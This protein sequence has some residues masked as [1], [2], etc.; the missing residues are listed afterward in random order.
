MVRSSK[1]IAFSCYAGTLFAFV[2]SHSRFDVKRHFS[3]NSPDSEQLQSLWSANIQ[4]MLAGTIHSPDQAY[5]VGQEL[6]LPLHAA[7]YLQNDAWERDISQHFS[8]FASNPSVLPSVVLDRLEYLYLAA[9]FL[10]L[11]KQSGRTDLVPSP[12]PDIVYSEFSKYWRSTPAWQW[13]RDPFS[14][15]IRERILWKLKNKKVQKSYYRALVDDDLFLLA[16]AADLKAFSDGSDQAPQWAPALD[17]AL[18]IALKVFSQEGVNLSDGGWLFQPGVWTDHPEYQ[19]AGNIVVQSGI[20]PAP[21][22]GIA[23][24]SSHSM[25]FAAWLSSF[26]LAYPPQSDNRLFYDGLRNKL[27]NQF[28]AKMLVPPSS[29]LSCYLLKNFT[30]GSNGV[31]R[32]EYSSLG[33]GSGYGPYQLSGSMLLGWWALLGTDRIRSLYSELDKAFPWTRQCISFYLGPAPGALH[34]ESSYDPNS[35]T[36]RLW[37]TIVALASAQSK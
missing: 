10:V 4:S 35:P 19:Y 24:D 26:A 1:L 29:D 30:D 14:G 23:T 15:G 5:T 34:P 8:R 3:S 25:R 17:D 21:V 31:Y 9:E 7:F 6:L 28:F 37:H 13:S 2:S 11:A 33:S 32:W 22:R 18:S 20:R 27:E 36:M 12:L 16:I